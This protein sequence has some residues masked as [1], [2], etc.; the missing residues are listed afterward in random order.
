MA[1]LGIKKVETVPHFLDRDCVFVRAMLDYK[2]FEVKEGPLV[3]HFLADLN[4][5]IPGV[6]CRQFG[7]IRTLAMHD[8]ILHFK[9]LLKNCVCEDLC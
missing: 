3:I 5:R 9:Y 1:P 6:L 7:A 4:E 8:H 2:L